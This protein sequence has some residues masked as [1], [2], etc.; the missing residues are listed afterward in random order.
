MVAKQR[1]MF[2]ERIAAMLRD[3]TDENRGFFDP[4]TDD[5]LTYAELLERCAVDRDTGFKLLPFDKADESNQQL[6][7]SSAKVLFESE[8]RKVT[9]QDVVE[10]DLIDHSLLQ[11]FQCGEMSAHEVKELVNTVKVH[12]EGSMPIAGILNPQTGQKY[13]IFEAAKGGLIRTGAAFELLEAQAACGKIIDVHAGRVVT[14]ETAARSGV[15]DRE[16]EVHVERALRAFEGY[17]EPFKKDILSVCEAIERHLIVERY[18]IRLL[19]AQVAT[20]GI[21]DARSPLRRAKEFKS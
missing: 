13:S 17:S 16:Y 7:P 5:N 4:N 15:F 1:D 20:G 14:L 2:S 21:V 10:A 18:G 12:V 8:L 19:E 3:P 11:R 9:L 6:A